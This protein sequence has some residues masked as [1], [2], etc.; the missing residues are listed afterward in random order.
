MVHHQFTGSLQAD[1]I[2]SCWPMVHKIRAFTESGKRILRGRMFPSVPTQPFSLLTVKNVFC[3]IS[4]KTFEMIVKKRLPSITSQKGCLWK[5]RG[6]HTTFHWRR[7]GSV[8]SPIHFGS[9]IRHHPGDC[10]T[11]APP[12][13]HPHSSRVSHRMVTEM[14]KDT[15]STS[16]S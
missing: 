10:S 7:G 13:P 3:N 12:H 6:T 16:Q 11:K 2:S 5:E 14:W 9:Y 1:E 4:G 15:W 8:L